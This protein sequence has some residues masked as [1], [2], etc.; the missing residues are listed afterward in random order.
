MLDAWQ[1]TRPP[2][3]FLV[4]QLDTALIVAGQLQVERGDRHTLRF[5][6]EIERVRLTDASQQQ[7][8]PDEQRG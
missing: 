5:E 7:T 1:L 4:K 8:G 2:K 3:D 6:S